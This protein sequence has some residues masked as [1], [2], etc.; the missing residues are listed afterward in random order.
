MANKPMDAPKSKRGGARQGGGRPKGSK[1]IYSDKS[2]EKLRE[3]G[4]DPIE[5]TVKMIQK[6]D[7]E[8]EATQKNKDGKDVY[9]IGRT[10]GAYAQLN[11]TRASLVNNLMKYGYQFSPTRKEE[12]DKED[13]PMTINFNMKT[14]KG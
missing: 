8:M 7:A 1:N 10:T 14:E 13:K 5:E 9:V 4:F 11:A 12:I 2:V 6:L 3:L